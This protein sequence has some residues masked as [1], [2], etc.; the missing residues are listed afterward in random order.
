MIILLKGPFNFVEG[1]SRRFA[2]EKSWSWWN[3]SQKSLQMW[4][5]RNPLNQRCFETKCLT[6]TNNSYQNTKNYSYTCI[7]SQIIWKSHKTAI[8]NNAS[9]RLLQENSA[10]YLFLVHSYLKSNK[11]WNSFPFGSRILFTKLENL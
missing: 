8:L 6:I 7:F 4:L 2:S 5:R 1:K 9:W 11:E 3:I 10:P